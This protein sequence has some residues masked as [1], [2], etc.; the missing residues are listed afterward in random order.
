MGIGR[1]NIACLMPLI[2]ALHAMQ[3]FPSWRTRGR[4]FEVVRKNPWET[5]RNGHYLG[6]G[7]TIPWVYLDKR[8][9][10]VCGAG[11]YCSTEVDCAAALVRADPCS[12]RNGH[13]GAPI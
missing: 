12:E 6:K 3:S 1:T 7:L 2:T 11:Y 10:I 8:V 9:C 4:V 13:I 5:L